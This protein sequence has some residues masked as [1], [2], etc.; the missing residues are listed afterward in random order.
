MD[1]NNKLGSKCLTRL[2]TLRSGNIT[3]LISL[4]SYF[5]PNKSISKWSTWCQKNR[6]CYKYTDKNHQSQ[7]YPWSLFSFKRLLY[8]ESI[9]DQYTPSQSHSKNMSRSGPYK[10]T[11]NTKVK[12]LVNTKTYYLERLA[13]GQAH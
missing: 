4:S 10:M 1:H 6:S 11:I 9:Q 12:N 7:N 8:Q 2:E 13:K 3:L 5:K